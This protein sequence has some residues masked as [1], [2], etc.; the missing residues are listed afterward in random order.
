MEQLWC[1]SCR[2]FTEGK[3]E[4]N[5]ITF[6]INQNRKVLRFVIANVKSTLC[7]AIQQKINDNEVNVLCANCL[8]I[9]SWE[10]KQTFVMEAQISNAF[11]LRVDAPDEETAKEVLT[12]KT[13][14]EIDEEYLADHSQ[15]LEFNVLNMKEV[16]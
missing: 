14:S 2:R 13:L 10:E 5:G 11:H 6:P 3:V 16:K 7:D 4:E 15:P 12:S 1:S 8:T 9:L